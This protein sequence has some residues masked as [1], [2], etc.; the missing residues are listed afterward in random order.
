[1]PGY[2]QRAIH[3]TL[4]IGFAVVDWFFFHDLFKPGEATNPVQLLV[5][6]LS[7]LVFL[8][9]A[10]ALVRLRTDERAG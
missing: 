6:L 2:V 9:S 1:M 7:V 4:I 8:T 3:A 10:A 5:G